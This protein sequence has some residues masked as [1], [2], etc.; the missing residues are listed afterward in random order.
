MRHHSR[1]LGW[2]FNNNATDD[3]LAFLWQ[4]LRRAK[5][6][7]SGYLAREVDRAPRWGAVPRGHTPLTTMFRRLAWNGSIWPPSDAT[8]CKFVLKRLDP[9]YRWGAESPW[10]PLHEHSGQRFGPS[11][12]AVSACLSERRADP[13]NSAEKNAEGSLGPD[14]GR[15]ELKP[16]HEHLSGCLPLGLCRMR[17]SELPRVGCAPPRSGIAAR[18]ESPWAGRSSEVV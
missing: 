1:T 13:A 16:S 17:G 2:H 8:A 7:P 5:R 15:R 3:F 12:R 6:L 4:R 14:K 11:L 10:A 9:V 18:G